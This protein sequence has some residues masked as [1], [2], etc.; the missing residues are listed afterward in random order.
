MDTALNANSILKSLP[1]GRALGPQRRERCE[2]AYQFDEQWFL[3]PDFAFGESQ[4][5]SPALV[6]GRLAVVRAP[7]AWQHR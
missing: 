3:H 7:V 6:A 2:Q 4:D 1:C 5:L